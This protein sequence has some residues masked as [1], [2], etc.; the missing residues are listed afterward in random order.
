MREP[1][2]QRDERGGK[3]KGLGQIHGGIIALF[4]SD[5]KWNSVWH[6]DRACCRNRVVA[7]RSTVA[8][9]A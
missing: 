3:A 2:A 9:P 4:L 7:N 1:R 5:E 6:Y 8:A